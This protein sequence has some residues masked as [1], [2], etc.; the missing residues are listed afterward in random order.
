MEA[1]LRSA[2]QTMTASIRASRA[3]VSLK[4]LR[5]VRLRFGR[6]T[7]NQLAKYSKQLADKGLNKVLKSQRSLSKN[8]KTHIKKLKEIKK[9]GGKGSSV[10]KEISNF[11]NELDAIKRVLR[12]SLLK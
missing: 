11:R 9:N 12:D 5:F 2:Y 6:A 3:R 7:P 10:E 8:L 1:A 4:A